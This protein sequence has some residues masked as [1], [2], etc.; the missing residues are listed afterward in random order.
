MLHL[1][2]FTSLFSFFL[3]ITVPINSD[4]RKKLRVFPIRK[5]D[6]QPKPRTNFTYDVKMAIPEKFRPQEKKAR[7]D[8]M[9]GYLG[10]CTL[11]N[12][13]RGTFVSML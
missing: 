3:G 4:S 7:R 13:Y 2:F 12:L 11:H 8:Y 6:K 5:D 1:V 9:W 10:E